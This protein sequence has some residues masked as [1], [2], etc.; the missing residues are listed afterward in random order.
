MPVSSSSSPIVHPPS[1]TRVLP[2]CGRYAHGTR[3]LRSGGRSGAGQLPSP[4]C[5]H[6]NSRQQPLSGLAALSHR[7]GSIQ[8]RVSLLAPPRRS[9]R[10]D[11][12]YG[13]AIL[14]ASATDA[15]P[16]SKAKTPQQIPDY[17]IDAPDEVR[18]FLMGGSAGLVGEFA[19]PSL[20]REGGGRGQSGEVR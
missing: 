6:R 5:R 10:A 15:R 9:L 16:M 13:S 4:Y 17:G 2:I 11:G 8:V 19:G 20:D 18:R 7:R 1:L 14:V 3:R 12:E